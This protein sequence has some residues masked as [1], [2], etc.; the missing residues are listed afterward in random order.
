MMH[1]CP[2]PQEVEAGGS[3]GTDPQGVELTDGE[4]A[5]ILV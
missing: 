5:S 2:G 1:A 4:L 3:D